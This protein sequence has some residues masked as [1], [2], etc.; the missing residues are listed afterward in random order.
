MACYTYSVLTEWFVSVYSG[1]G[2]ETPL[3]KESKQR[4][5]D[6]PFRRGVSAQMRQLR[7]MVS[8]V[9]SRDAPASRPRH[10]AG[11]TRTWQHP[12]GGRPC[13]GLHGL[14]YAPA[15]GSGGARG[16]PG[17]TI[18]RRGSTVDITIRPAGAR[19]RADIGLG[20]APAT[21]AGGTVC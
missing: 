16:G 15:A 2:S 17:T 13:P 5:P 4:L 21:G 12:S 9:W 7:A 14:G 1:A 20:Y 8:L 19:A 18:R 3:S 10:G 6:F 11:S